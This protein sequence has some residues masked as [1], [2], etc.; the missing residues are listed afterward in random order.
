L[1]NPQ[2]ILDI[3]T[4]TGQWSIEIADEFPEAEVQATD[5]SP[6][7]PTDVPENL[8]FFIDDAREEDWGVPPGHFD[9]VHT[10]VLVGCF[11]DF[12]DIIR[13]GFLYTKPG[14]YMESQEIMSIPF[15]DDG[16]MPA[17]WPFLEWSKIV[18]E[19]AVTAERPVDIANRLKGWYEQAGFVD[20]QEQVFK[21][22]MTGW[23]RDLHLRRLGRMSEENWHAGLSAFS[24]GFF[25]RILKWTKT[26]IEVFLVDVRK[27]LSE[28]QVHA[29]HKIYVVWGRK[30]LEGEQTSSTSQSTGGQTA[31]G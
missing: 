5:L 27:C 7:Q 26:E 3:G 12:G 19:A 23:P 28:R 14:G 31:S 24:M 17:D 9:Y 6:I 25:S 13:K 8:Q 1:S 20:V 22:P 18:H 29:Y 10:R 21:M 11:P 30:P 2:R 16:T 15:C 4:G